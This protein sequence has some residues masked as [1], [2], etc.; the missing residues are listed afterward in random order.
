[1][2]TEQKNQEESSKPKA[3]AAISMLI[4]AALLSV[5]IPILAI[6]YFSG[7]ERAYLLMQIFAV[8]FGVSFVIFVASI[9]IEGS[10]E[11]GGNLLGVVKVINGVCLVFLAFVALRLLVVEIPRLWRDSWLLF[12]LISGSLAFVIYYRTKRKD[13]EK[14]DPQVDQFEQ[15]PSSD[16]NERG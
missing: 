4:S 6:W 1:M 14:E 12:G 5:I 15:D 8:L 10:I 7:T 9:L 3:I 13:S 2:A 16:W 11:K